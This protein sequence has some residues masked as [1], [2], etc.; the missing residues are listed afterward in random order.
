LENTHGV[1]FE[2]HALANRLHNILGILVPKLD[3]C[4]LDVTSARQRSRASN[5]LP[6]AVSEH[7]ITSLPL[8]AKFSQNILFST[9]TESVSL[10][11]HILFCSDCKSYHNNRLCGSFSLKSATFH[12]DFSK[13]MHNV[14]TF[15]YICNRL[16]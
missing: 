16:E 15:L 8:F 12:E 11:C 5:P 9:H 1:F 6:Q 4:Y 14:L 13:N 10:F 3:S 7:D 2:T